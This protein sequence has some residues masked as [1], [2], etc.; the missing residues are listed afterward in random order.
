MDLFFLDEY[1]HFRLCYDQTSSVKT[2]IVNNRFHLEY[3]RGKGCGSLNNTV[4]TSFSP[5][6]QIMTHYERAFKI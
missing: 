4:I 6:I 5:V 3:I 2:A 1:N